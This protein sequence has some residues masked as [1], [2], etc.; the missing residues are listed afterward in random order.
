MKIPTKA[1]NPMSGLW[2]SPKNTL[3]HEGLPRSWDHVQPPPASFILP[4]NPH[5]SSLRQW[6]AFRFMTS[7]RLNR[8]LASIRRSKWRR[9]RMA[10]SASCTMPRSFP[11]Q[12]S[13]R[14]M[15]LVQRYKHVFHQENTCII[16]WNPFQLHFYV[17]FLSIYFLCITR[18][19]T[20]SRRKE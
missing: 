16:L 1:L 5:T 9:T 2:Y 11:V 18:S 15:L 10:S 4:R 3:R 19:V 7:S 12:T 6:N 8:F 13:V 17:L 20:S 14:N